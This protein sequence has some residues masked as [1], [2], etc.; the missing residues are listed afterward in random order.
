MTKNR[1][2]DISTAESL[3]VDFAKSLGINAPIIE[4]ILHARAGEI[5]TCTITS[6]VNPLDSNFRIETN[7]YK[8]ELI[9]E[10]KC[11]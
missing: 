1:R 3:I 7:K 9:K 2:I 5:P 8:L 11:L 6:Y 10:S 4:F